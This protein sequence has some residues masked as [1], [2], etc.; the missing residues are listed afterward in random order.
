LEKTLDKFDAIDDKYADWAK[1]YKEEK[2][3]IEKDA[4]LSKNENIDEKL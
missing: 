2:P 4:N 3:K 1:K